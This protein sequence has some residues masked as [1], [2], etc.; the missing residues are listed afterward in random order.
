MTENF[1]IRDAE[2]EDLG[3]IA[4]LVVRLKRLNEEF[5]PLLR[6]RDDAHEVAKKEYQKA[7]GSGNDVVLVILNKGEIVGLLK[8]S[9]KERKYYEPRMEGVIEDFYI[10]PAHRRKSIGVRLLQK[11]TDELKKKGAGL[12]VAEFPLQ[13]KIAAEFYQKMGFRAVIGVYGKD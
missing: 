1:E 7:I 3:K 8:A 13:N 10:M 6:V 4:D 12:I 9:I 2:P 11:A 5:D